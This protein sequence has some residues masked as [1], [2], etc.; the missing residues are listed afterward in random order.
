M[1]SGFT[2]SINAA[3]TV[4]YWTNRRNKE[5]STVIGVSKVRGVPGPGAPLRV[6]TRGPF[7]SRKS[8]ERV[9][10]LVSVLPQSK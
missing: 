3:D 9:V 10:A 7:Q 5:K 1:I 4:L 8:W 2:E 6:R